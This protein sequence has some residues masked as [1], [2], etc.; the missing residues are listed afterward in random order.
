MRQIS[1]KITCYHNENNSFSTFY[2]DNSF[3]TY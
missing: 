2:K 3:L 1:H